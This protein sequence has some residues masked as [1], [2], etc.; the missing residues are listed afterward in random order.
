MPNGMLLFLHVLGFLT[1]KGKEKNT[2]LM[3]L[4]IKHGIFLAGA[5]YT[6]KISEIFK[7]LSE[8]NARFISFLLKSSFFIF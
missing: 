3:A 2:Y 4:F 6:I 5:V 7:L 1:F 8:N